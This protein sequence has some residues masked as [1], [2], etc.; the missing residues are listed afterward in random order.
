VRDRSTLGILWRRKW[1]VVGTFAIFVVLGAVISKVLPK[2]YTAT[3][4][5]VVVQKEN[6]AS[7]DAVQAAQVTART[8]SDIVS[9]PVIAAQVARQLGG[10][11]SQKSVSSAVSVSPVS[12][13][14][15]LRITAEDRNAG[16]AQ[17]LAN[18][19]AAAVIEYIRQNV[20]PTV[21]ANVALASAATRP[22]SPSRPKPT[23][24]VLVAAIIGLC[25]GVGAAFLAERLDTGL[26]SAEEVRERFDEL[27]LARMPRRGRTPASTNAFNEAFGLLRTN[28]SFASPDKPPKLIAVTSAREGEGKTTCVV[29]IASAMAEIED[30]VIV[31]DAD[32]RRPALQRVLLPERL[33][34]LQPGLSNHLLGSCSLGEILHPTDTDHISFVPTGPLPPSPAAFLESH[35]VEPALRELG[36]RADM[37]LID[38][39]PMSA[40]AD[41]AV[42]AGRVDG[43]I[44]VVDLASADERSVREV[45]HQL[46]TVRALVLGFVL[47]RDRAMEFAY[48]Y[49]RDERAGS[50]SVV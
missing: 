22:T 15:L 48:D 30:R 42:L 19:Y 8:Y 24:Y 39:P 45:L 1:V 23:L 20:G 44:V 33:E 38:C 27:I 2:V 49:E 47:N 14:Q 13:T 6:S 32:F 50:G 40:G 31:V 28:L 16:K 46:K 29:Q 18:V 5:L 3:S 10:G 25:F 4:S 12:E 11:E 26:R 21:G 34:R 43:V 17:R 9:A 41:A 36:E 7:F 37:V 35:R